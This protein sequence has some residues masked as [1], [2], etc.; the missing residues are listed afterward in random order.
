MRTKRILGFA[1]GLSAALIGC[2][3][4]PSLKGPS[5]IFDRTHDEF[6]DVTNGIAG[7]D[8]WSVNEER[9]FESESSGDSVGRARFCD[10]A[11]AD[12]QVQEMIKA[13]I[14]PDNSI[15]Q[16]PLWGAE[17]TPLLADSL[18]GSPAD[19]KFCDPSGTY[20]N[21]FTFGPLNE[22]VVI[23][24]EETR[25]IDYVYAQPGY[26]GALE[27]SAKNAAGI[28]QKIWI[29]AGDP[30]RVGNLELKDDAPDSAAQWSNPVNINHIYRMI[31]G[32][33]FPAAP[34]PAL[35]FDCLGARICRI[36]E[37][38]ADR[39]LRIE[40]SGVV[41]S[42]PA[43][44]GAV[45]FIM[46]QPVRVAPFEAA[47]D[48]SFGAAALPDPAAPTPLDPS[49]ETSEPVLAPLSPAFASDVFENC[50]LELDG[51]TTWAK[52]KSGCIK[53]DDTLN[54]ASFDVLNGRGA[55]RVDFNGVFLTFLHADGAPLE[56]GARPAD[57][58]VLIGVSFTD[59]LN[60]SFAQWVPQSLG[61]QFKQRLEATVQGS[62]LASVSDHPFNDF[63]L[64]ALPPLST[65]AEAL[66]PLTAATD[67]GPLDL[68]NTYIAAAQEAYAALTAEQAAYVN[69]DL[70][71]KTF[72][73]AP[74]VEAAL[75]V[76]TGG[77]SDDPLSVL[78]TVPSDDSLYVIGRANFTIDGVPYRVF[79]Q[80][81]FVFGG[82]VYVGMERGFSPIDAPINAAAAEFA[83]VLPSLASNYYE[84]W[85]GL[86]PSVGYPFPNPFALGATDIRVTGVDRQLN[87]LNVEIASTDGEGAP[88]TYEL[89]LRGAHID[90]GSGFNRQTEGETWEFLRSHAIS[91]DGRETSLQV[92]VDD[93]GVVQQTT[94][95]TFKG[96]V[97]LCGVGSPPMVV[98]GQ[99]VR[100]TLDAFARK[101]PKAYRDC[102]I[103]FN[104]SPNG[105]VLNSVASVIN[106]V[107]ITLSGGRAVT[108]S[109]WQ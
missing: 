66:S 101:S 15:G 53:A 48:M 78:Y 65:T 85:Q 9:G 19:S 27:G 25:L 74:F 108:V 73:V 59:N 31:R 39:A 94:Q 106:K 22:V 40:D 82:I 60:G 24:N 89:K 51:T 57:G 83:K 61:A 69:P 11:Q 35:D 80:Y 90:D 58:D 5:Q 86:L 1:V 12:A 72:L 71:K 97:Y 84:H 14:I 79:A 62:L 6:T 98:Y 8:P 13:P 30:I 26:L 38:G 107:S 4:G 77:H 20:S 104:Y 37:I 49:E 23:F 95:Y 75:A 105:N 21:A 91:F 103:V 96:P 41:L 68:V 87:M 7:G 67:S 2:E 63:S 50:S 43:N 18:L 76:L 54:R 100:A 42:F 109:A 44:G 28:E 55:V 92:H 16:I 93:N 102:G 36:L 70:P 32:T 46:V 17:Y 56:D 29:R 52:F 10:Q 45:Q 88:K 33:F 47:M 81:N 34:A 99:D 64:G 3:D